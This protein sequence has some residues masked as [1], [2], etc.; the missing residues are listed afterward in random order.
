[1]N[2]RLA[3][4]VSFFS[5]F[6]LSI[7]SFSQ[8]G[9]NTPTPEPSSALDIS[10][11]TQGFLPPR[12]SEGDRDLILSPA[13]GLLIYNT[14]T[15]RL[16]YYDG[17]SW[18]AVVTSA[19]S[20][21]DLTTNQTIGGAKTFTGMLTPE[22]RLMLPMGELNYYNYSGFVTAS[23]GTS[24]ATGTDGMV[25][26]NP[27]SG[28]NFVNDAFGTG[29]NTRLTYTG[30]TTRL[31]HVA[32]SFSFSPGSSTE[33]IFGVA[34]NGV[35]QDSS[36]VILKGANSGDYQSSAIHV[37]LSLSQND[38]LEFYF[39]RVGTAGTITI[40]TINFFAMGM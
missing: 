38:Y 11:T 24:G 23:G 6:L 22:G 34:K 37:L 17:T 3:Y 5:L 20:F 18:L 28:V 36:K 27:P 16:N 40:K 4:L 8:V 19:G 9:I 14:T 7:Q 2:N 10:S 33:Y 30:A 12:M 32:L 21:V 1:M 13:V 15:N 25:K 39:G 35:V 31:F 29:T 26:V